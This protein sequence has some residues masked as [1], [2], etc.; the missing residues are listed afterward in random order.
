MCTQIVYANADIDGERGIR[1]QNPEID[2]EQSK[3]H[4]HKNVE[5]AQLFGGGRKTR[6]IIKANFD[7]R[8]IAF[9]SRHLAN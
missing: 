7:I 8:S 1:A 4:N 5:S 3:F 2:I 6:L 9:F